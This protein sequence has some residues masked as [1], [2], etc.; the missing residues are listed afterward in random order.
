M[1]ELKQAFYEVMYKYQKLHIVHGINR[2]VCL[3]GMGMRE[4]KRSF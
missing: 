4:E 2:K 3:T 1:E